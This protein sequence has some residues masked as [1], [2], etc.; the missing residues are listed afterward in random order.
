M[1]R[2][3]TLI[4]ILLGLAINTIALASL[5]G[6]ARDLALIVGTALGASMV[7]ASIGRALLRAHVRAELRRLR[8]EV[9]SVRTGVGSRQAIGT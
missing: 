8:E 9:A 4:A 5:T 6:A 1:T 2:Y 7:G 3:R